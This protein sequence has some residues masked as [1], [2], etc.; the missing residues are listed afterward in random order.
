[1]HVAEKLGAYIRDSENLQMLLHARRNKVT[2]IHIPTP[3]AWLA[4]RLPLQV[5][6]SGRRSS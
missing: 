6:H 4:L 2:N 5:G 1:M 3:L